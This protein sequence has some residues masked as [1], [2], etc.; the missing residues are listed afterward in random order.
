[1]CLSLAAPAHAASGDVARLTQSIVRLV[2]GK[3]AGGERQAGV[4]IDLGDGWKTYWRMPGESG[5]PPDFDWSGSSNVAHVDVGWPAPH[6]MHDAGGESIGYKGEVLFPLTVRLKTPGQPARLDLKLF[7]AVCKDICVPAKAEVSLDLGATPPAT[8]DVALIR[9]FQTLVPAED[10][11]ASG[12][13]AA[14]ALMHDGKPALMVLVARDVKAGPH[15]DIFVEGFDDGYFR[16]P[17]TSRLSDKGREFI[18]PVDGIK[19]ASALTGKR[20]RITF[21]G[22]GESLSRSLEV[23]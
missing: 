9:H 17:A 1:M 3:A 18:L 22:A 19:D 5:V 14:R 16:A 12:L 2:Q 13:I 10:N 21:I 23:E 8:A 6:R 11:A 4:N 7:Y 15:A 20:L